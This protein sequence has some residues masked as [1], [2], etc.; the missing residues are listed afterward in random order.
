MH[1]NLIGVKFELVQ[2]ELDSMVGME[3]FKQGQSM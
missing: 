1:P 2:L 3:Q